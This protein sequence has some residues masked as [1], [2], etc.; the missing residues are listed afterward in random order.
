M[1]ETSNGLEVPIQSEDI[2]DSWK[3]IEETL[4]T[5]SVTKCL[6]NDNQDVQVSSSKDLCDYNSPM[7]IEN[8]HEICLNLRM[9]KKEE[10]VEDAT[11][12][13]NPYLR[14]DLPI[15]Y[16]VIGRAS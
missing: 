5:G 15:S 14:I 9:K 6:S 7:S 10:R 13:L 12:Q 1:N 4:E 16:R 11:C 2:D 3:Q 8:F